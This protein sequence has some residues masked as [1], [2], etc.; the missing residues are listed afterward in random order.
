MF[1]SIYDH[2][3]YNRWIL[4]HFRRCNQMRRY[5]PPDI[6]ISYWIFWKKWVDYGISYGKSFK[7]LLRLH[8]L[9]N[10]SQKSLHKW[11]WTAVH[12]PYLVC[13][14]PRI[15]YITGR[16][17]GNSCIYKARAIFGTFISTHAI[18]RGYVFILWSRSEG[19]M[20]DA[21]HIPQFNN[22]TPD[23]RTWKYLTLKIP[24]PE[25]SKQINI[26]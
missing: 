12:K 26:T 5:L 2:D 19:S 25:L 24:N 22:D 23:A 14:F 10:R 17:S 11:K 4:V 16:C 9:Q 3:P 20:L 21:I 13:S 1:R 15:C 18:W 6:L 7:W 8:D